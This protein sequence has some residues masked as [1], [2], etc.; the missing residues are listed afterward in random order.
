E[1]PSAV[2]T[3]DYWGGYVIYWLYP[4]RL[5]AVDDRHDLYGE[6]FLKSY[7]KMMH[8]EPGWDDLLREY[9][10]HCV[11]VPR[12]SALSNILGEMNEWQSIYAD[13]VAIVFVRSVDWN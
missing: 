5:A 6:N 8:V 1:T 12:G 11:L 9:E 7:L 10:I 13:D 4:H 2:L 3:P